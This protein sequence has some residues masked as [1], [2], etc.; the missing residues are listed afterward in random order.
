MEHS[1]IEPRA[2]SKRLTNVDAMR[3]LAATLVVWIHVSE[4]WVKSHAQTSSDLLYQL[5]RSWALAG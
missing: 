3:G 1:A 4:M 2:H 5:P